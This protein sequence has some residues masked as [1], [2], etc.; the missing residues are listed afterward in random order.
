MTTTH[1]ATCSECGEK[2]E[3]EDGADQSHLL[4]CDECGAT[5]TVL[6]EDMGNLRNGY[7]E[8]INKP[9]AALTLEEDVMIHNTYSGAFVSEDEYQV[10]VEKFAG[11]CS[12]GGRFLF[13]ALPRCPKCKSASVSKD[14]DKK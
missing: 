12:C 2:F 10:G 3:I 13:A 7:L 5:T 4:R 8:G 1:P 9:L 11:P 14:A 6:F